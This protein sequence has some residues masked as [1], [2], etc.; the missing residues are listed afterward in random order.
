MFDIATKRTRAD[1]L[2]VLRGA[3]ALYVLVGHLIAWAPLTSGMPRL[4]GSGDKR[5]DSVFQGVGQTN[6]AVIGFI[7]LSGYCIHRHGFRPDR[8]DYWAY[9]I[10]RCFRI[11]PVYVAA[12]I[13]G[14]L[15]FTAS[16]SIDAQLTRQLTGTSDVGLGCMAAKIS[17]AAAFVPSLHACAFQGNAPLATVMAEI[18]LYVAYA[19]L[20]AILLSRGREMSLWIIVGLVWVGGTVWTAKHQSEL[21]W[22]RNGS[23]AGFLAYWWIGAKATQ[24]TA[25]RQLTRGGPLIAIGWLAATVILMT[26]SGPMP[27]LAALQQLLLA[28]LF[29]LLLTRLDIPYVDAGTRAPARLGVAGYSV[30]AFH[31]PLLIL[32]LLAGLPWWMAGLV[33]VV[34][35]LASYRFFERPFL[36]IGRRIGRA[37]TPQR[38]RPYSLSQAHIDEKPCAPVGSKA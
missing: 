17:G 8:L 5:L 3:L 1:G 30:Y 28:G 38:D 16:V 27:L 26:S 21:G 33:A 23:V 18:W 14:A 13:L 36:Q 11:V 25:A 9:A 12:V 20:V 34:V 31:A 7:V 19:A 10:R 15:A 29:A 4:L 37:S 24:D 2:D 6:P 35:G 32:L 22:W